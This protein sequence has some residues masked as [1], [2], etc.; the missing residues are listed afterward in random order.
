[1]NLALKFR[2]QANEINSVPR[3]ADLII[4]KANEASLKGQYEVEVN[5]KKEFAL[6]ISDLIAQIVNDRLEKYGFE[7][8]FTVN[9]GEKIFTVSFLNYNFASLP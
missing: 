3:I 1:M 4:E 5:L 8:V 7:S 6:I 9:G 2:D